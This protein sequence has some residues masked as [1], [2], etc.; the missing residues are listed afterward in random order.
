[1]SSGNISEYGSIAMYFIKFNGLVLLCA[2]SF[3]MTLPD[4]FE[5]FSDFPSGSFISNGVI[6]D[7]IYL[8][9]GRDFIS[10]SSI[11]E[12]YFF[13][14][15]MLFETIFFIFLIFSV[16]VLKLK[17]EFDFV[18]I[19]LVSWYWKNW[20]KCYRTLSAILW[21]SYKL[22][23]PLKSNSDTKVTKTLSFDSHT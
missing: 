16:F 9:S 2:K 17:S 10:E 4:T 1:M 15:S 13:V 3:W 11:L 7:F 19:N 12:N 18:F 23:Y 6:E 20:G 21:L 14:L 8:S 5:I 22:L